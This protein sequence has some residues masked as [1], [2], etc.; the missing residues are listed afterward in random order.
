MVCACMSVGKPGNGGDLDIHCF[1]ILLAKRL[2]Y[3]MVC[4][5]APFLNYQAKGDFGSKP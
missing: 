5:S 4:P 2:T 1:K 3:L